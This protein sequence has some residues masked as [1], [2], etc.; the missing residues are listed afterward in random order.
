MLAAETP[1]SVTLR[2]GEGVEDVVLRDDLESLTSTRQ[3]LMPDGLEEQIDPQQMADL[4][5]FLLRAK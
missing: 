5:Q 1:A 4:V 3:S 2:R